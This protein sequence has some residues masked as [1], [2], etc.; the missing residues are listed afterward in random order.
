MF[1][2]SFIP[3]LSVSNTLAFITSSLD[4]A[5]QLCLNISTW[6]D[7]TV[8]QTD[9]NYWSDVGDIQW[10][11]ISQRGDSVKIVA[12]NHTWPCTSCSSLGRQGPCTTVSVLEWRDASSVQLVD[13]LTDYGLSCRATAPTH[14]LGGLLD[15]VAS[16]DDLPPP[17]VEVVNV[18]LSDHRFVRWSDDQFW[19]V[20]HPLTTLQ[21]SFDRGVSLMLTPSVM[22]IDVMSAGHVEELRRR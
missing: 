22:V 18:G 6:V 17:S 10:R 9:C 19:R 8:F 15:I 4:R 14:D 5:N 13:L 7:M 12:F 21:P 16:H 2:L 1:I 3:H 20:G 11:L